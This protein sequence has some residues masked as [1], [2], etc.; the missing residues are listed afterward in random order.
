MV[1][2]IEGEGGARQWDRIRTKVE[3]KRQLPK[4]SCILRVVIVSTHKFVKRY[5]L[6]TQYMVLF[7]GFSA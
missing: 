3:I 1:T 6:V 4:E 2:M 7:F 5:I